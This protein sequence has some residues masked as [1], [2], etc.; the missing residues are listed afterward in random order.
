MRNTLINFYLD[1]VNNYLTV[2][3]CAEDNGV[4][5]MQCL[6]LISIGKQLHEKQVQQYKQGRMIDA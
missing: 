5:V 3:K 6:A 2:A 4:S 1:Y